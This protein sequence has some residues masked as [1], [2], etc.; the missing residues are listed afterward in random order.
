[1]WRS[2]MSS[3]S[4][5]ELDGDD[6]AG[7]ILAD[8]E[9]PTRRRTVWQR[10]VLDG[11]T[12]GERL[13]TKPAYRHINLRTG[14]ELALAITRAARDMHMSRQ[15]WM[16]HVLA[17]EVVRIQGGDYDTLIGEYGE[18]PKVWRIDRG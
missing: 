7:R 9:G 6:E 5:V 14:G 11:M 13:A 10:K 17:T 12:G 3:R 18:P 15:S 8:D 2:Q 16:R 1:M 4:R